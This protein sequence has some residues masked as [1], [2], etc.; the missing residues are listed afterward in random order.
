[1]NLQP[2]LKSQRTAHLLFGNLPLWIP[3]ARCFAR[4]H[5]LILTIGDHGPRYVFRQFDPDLHAVPANIIAHGGRTQIP[6]V[7]LANQ[8]NTEV[9]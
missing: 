4:P 2:R 9:E 1:M 6:G 3:Q 5:A 7:T 8:S